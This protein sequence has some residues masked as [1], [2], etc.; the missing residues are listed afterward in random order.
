MITKRLM[1]LIALVSSAALA[2]DPQQPGDGNVPAPD[3][4]D[5]QLQCTNEL[6][7]MRPTP[8]M[9]EKGADASE[10]DDAIGM[11]TR[12]L[13]GQI[14]T[15]LGYVVPAMGSNCG[16]GLTSLAFHELTHSSIAIDVAEG[17]SELL[18]KFIAVYGDP[19]IQTDTGTAGALRLAREALQLAEADDS[20]TES[21]LSILRDAVEDAEERDMQA[22]AE[23][24]TLAQGPINQAGVA[25]WMAKAAVTQAV[26]DYNA[27]VEKAGDAQRLVDAMNYS[28]YVPLGR[29]DLVNSVVLIV[30]DTATINFDALRNYIDA[31]GTRMAEADADGVYDTTLS[32]FDS[33]GNLVV[34][35]RLSDGALVHVTRSSRVDTIRMNVEDHETALAALKERQT[36]NVNLVLQPLLDEAVRRAQAETD[37]YRAQLQNALSD[38]TNQNPFTVDLPSTPENEAAPYSIASRNAD[39]IRASN[40]RLIAETT[41]RTAAAER[42][43][44][45]QNVIDS[46]QN[47]GSFYAQLVARRAA[48]KDVADRDVTRA[49]LGGATPSMVL[50]DAA[51]AAAEALT[52]AQDAL[53]DYEVLVSD[54]EGPVVELV[55]TLLE[56]D[57]DDGG[58]VVKAITQTYDATKVNKD[59]IDGL[60]ADT[61]DGAETDGP[62]TAN[63]KAAA[64]NA[65]KIDSLDGRVGQNESDIETLKQDTDTNTG[66]ISTNAGNIAQNASNISVNANSIVDN[67]ALISQNAVTLVDH[68]AR[69]DRNASHI[70][71]NSERIGANAAAISMNSGL[72]SDNRH[73][74]GE[75]SSDLQVVRAGVA[76][77]I[78]LSRMPSIDGGGVSFGAGVFAGEVAYA[79]GYQMQ[80]GFGTFDIGL[81]SSGGE[82]GAGVGVGLK[83]W[84]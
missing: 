23:F 82:V 11:G 69:I 6:P 20:S 29:S 32:N 15:D 40:D 47:P 39:H 58:A 83:L 79:V 63:R 3:L 53:A 84:H 42:E 36:N 72:I 64:A 18:P 10:L 14:V 35:N 54:P 73:M 5:S 60:T 33:S 68:G 44:A 38:N 46:F 30:G 12:R 70:S 62:V 7:T 49:S 4:F 28:S 17:Y 27:A 19:G 41:L 24:D 81:T 9:R 50:V 43:A 61:E 59:S 51:A 31:S 55:D 74:I 1:A 37:H 77:S 57:G 26:A 71:L 78:A 13:I 45:T 76:A 21:Q 34:P 75:L 48:L 22:R 67:R 65:E 8:S 66:M 25:E 16:A 56:T 2:Q 52:E 80:R